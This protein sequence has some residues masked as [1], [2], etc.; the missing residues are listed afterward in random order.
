MPPTPAGP[1]ASTEQRLQA[2]EDALSHGDERMGDLERAVAANT[3]L[4]AEFR[5]TFTPYSH[6]F[7][8]SGTA[9]QVQE[10]E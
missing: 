1:T 3:D 8:V 10:Q 4:T 6:C 5:E 2:I 7:H 9:V